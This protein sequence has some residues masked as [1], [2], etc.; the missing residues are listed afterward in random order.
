M[1]GDPYATYNPITVATF[2]KVLPQFHFSTYLS[3][4]TPRSFPETVIVTDPG[5]I[6]ALSKILNDTPGEVIEA[7]L[8]TRAALSLSTFLG[9]ETEPWLAVR[10]LEEELRGIKKGA[11]G[12]RAEF[13]I[14]KVET[15]L[16]FAAGR[17]FVKETFA[18]DSKK[19]GTKVITDVIKTFKA[20]LPNIDWMD[21]KSASAAA[22]KVRLLSAFWDC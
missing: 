15:T 7:Y 18:G 5:Y 12:D 6:T 21:Q 2:T 4:F 17:Y 13:C 22:A 19:I 14:S 8:V 1:Y 20:S 3:T 10:S 16:G 11:V 9:Q